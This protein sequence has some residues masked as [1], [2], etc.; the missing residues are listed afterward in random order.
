M[1]TIEILRETATIIANEQLPKADRL[2]GGAD[3]KITL[4]PPKPAS[5]PR[6]RSEPRYVTTTRA[7]E[8]SWIF[9][10][11]RDAFYTEN[12]LDGCSKIEFFGRLAN[13]ANRCIAQGHRENATNLCLA[14]LHEAFAIYEEMESGDFASL[15]I[16]QDGEIVGDY[17]EGQGAGYRNSEHTVQYLRDR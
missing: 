17:T 6:T 9:E 10:H 15:A 7:K 13:A 4:N 5:G 8:L 1:S 16:A 12:R 14:V 3:V 11:L 2:W